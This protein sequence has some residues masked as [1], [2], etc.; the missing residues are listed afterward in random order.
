MKIYTYKNCGTCKKAIQWLKAQEIACEELPIRETPP[1]RAELEQMLGY[2]ADDLRKLFNTAGGDYRELN[3]KDKLPTMATAEA[4][5]ILSQ[6][7]NLVKRPFL[8]GEG[9]GLVGFK[10]AVWADTLL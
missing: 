9:Y 4:I 7:G 5:E 3:M 10:E 2:Q 6:R 8:I 1:T